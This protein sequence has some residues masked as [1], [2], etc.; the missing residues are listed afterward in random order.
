M[1]RADAIAVNSNF[2][3][4]MFKQAFPSIKKDP[5]VIYPPVDCATAL[6]WTEEN[7]LEAIR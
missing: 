4:G 5:I 6:N 1:S 7:R 3:K 2:T